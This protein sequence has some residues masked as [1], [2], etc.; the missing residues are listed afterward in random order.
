MS[1]FGNFVNSL[2]NAQLEILFSTV[3]NDHPN[4]VKILF[5]LGVAKQIRDQKGNTLLHSCPNQNM[6][7]LLLENGI[8]IN[9]RN[10]MAQT[11]LHMAMRNKVY[12]NKRIALHDHII[13]LIN[14]GIDVNAQENN[15][16]TALHLAEHLDVARALLIAGANPNIKDKNN[17]TPLHIAVRLI[18]DPRIIAA[19]IAAGAD[20]HLQNNSGYTASDELQKLFSS[21]N[22]TLEERKKMA[23]INELLNIQTVAS[24]DDEIL[25]MTYLAP[26]APS[27][28]TID[29]II[30][31]PQPEDTT[32]TDTDNSAD[33][34]STFCAL[35]QISLISVMRN[36]VYKNLRSALSVLAL[37]LIG[38]G[39]DVNEQEE[40]TGMAPLH[41]AE[42]ILI[43]NALLEHGAEVDIQN[44]V[45]D[46]P[47]HVA[48][49][50]PKD[51]QIIASLMRSGADPE[52]AND[53]GETSLDVLAKLAERP[54][55]S[56]N[57]VRLINDI[58][59]PIA[60]PNS[61]VMDDTNALLAD[62]EPEEQ[63]T[64]VVDTPTTTLTTA[65]NT[66]KKRHHRN[67]G[68]AHTR[69]PRHNHHRKV[70]A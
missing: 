70:R 20:R 9:A 62:D 28:D 42:N 54:D 7:K 56:K 65:F 61:L 1:K 13:F 44:N 12:L 52:I 32:E 31:A 19:L 22:V 50:K 60:H 55:V 64:N 17:D 63:E 15:G 33:D 29:P 2:R 25:S 3:R 43:A 10:D 69:R 41:L 23:T 66:H 53:A 68:H 47:L 38:N 58:V 18:K 51:I 5:F 26:G 49:R 11:A 6:G 21:I 59:H 40:S 46:T 45:G 34:T 67:D 8:T 24:A 4:L 48:I 36:S 39:A 16:Y 30:E 57:T 35:D 27:E 14:S 37:E